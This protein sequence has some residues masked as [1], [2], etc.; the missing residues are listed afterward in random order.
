MLPTCLWIWRGSSSCPC[1]SPLTKGLPS[2]S[3]TWAVSQG[4]FLLTL[5]QRKGSSSSADKTGHLVAHL[6]MGGV[7]EPQKLQTGV[8]PVSAVLLAWWLEST[9]RL[10]LSASRS[11]VVSAPGAGL[12]KSLLEAAWRLAILSPSLWSSGFYQGAVCGAGPGP[13]MQPAGR[14]D[15]ESASLE[16]ARKTTPRVRP[17]TQSRSQS[18]SFLISQPRLR[19]HVTSSCPVLPPTT[20][21]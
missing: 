7:T 21:C 15:S 1:L 10:L 14:V 12:R 3:S 16:P 13:P 20:S 2:S 4:S 11:H 5:P 6:P 9:A 8:H 18:G 17:N 19:H